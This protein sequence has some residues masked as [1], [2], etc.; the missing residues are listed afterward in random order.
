MGFHEVVFPE[1]I[2]YG[3]SGGPGFKTSIITVN[4]GAEERVAHWSQARRKFDVAEAI[5]SYAELSQ[6]IQFYKARLG[7]ANGFLFKDWSDYATTSDGILHA[8]F[9]TVITHTD[10]VI[11]VGDGARTQFQLTKTYAD[12]GGSHTRTITRPKS[13]TV[14][15]GVDGANLATGWTLNYSTG[16]LNL[17]TAPAAGKVV[18]WGGQFYVPV[19]FGDE[20]DGQLPVSLDDYN[21]GSVRIPLVELQDEVESSDDF[22]MGGAVEV[23]LQ[24]NYNLD[25]L[26]R[27]FIFKATSAGHSV[28][29]PNHAASAG[30]QPGGPFCYV[31]NDATSPNSFS[32][33]D[34]DGNLITTVNAGAGVTM[35]LSIDAVGTRVWYAK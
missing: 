11:G 18:T 14:L 5:K 32:L 12:I 1:D 7:C 9:P 16:V 26:H 2:S 29:L 28:F 17:A 27:V 6:L 35:L 31:I 15:V 24:A 3:S 4:S 19:R 10:Q 8:E 20:L 25:S 34:Y 33:K 30:L 21:S 13:G 23:E 22:F